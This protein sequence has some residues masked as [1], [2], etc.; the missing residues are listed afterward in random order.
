MIKWHR[1][2]EWNGR[3]LGEREKF[4]PQRNRLHPPHLVGIKGVRVPDGELW[5]GGE[6]WLQRSLNK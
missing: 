6:L 4:M 5:Q 2:G 3:N 1:G